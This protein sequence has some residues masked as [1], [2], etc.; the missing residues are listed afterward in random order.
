MFPPNPAPSS[1][2]VAVLHK[3]KLSPFFDTNFRLCDCQHQNN[4]GVPFSVFR[5]R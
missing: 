2:P 4:S 3:S 1:N 5:T